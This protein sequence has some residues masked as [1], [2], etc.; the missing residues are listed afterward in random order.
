MT[1]HSIVKKLIGEIDPVGDCD[2]DE[3]RFNNL[4]NMINLVD[5]LIGDLERVALEADRKEFSV[6]RAG[7]VSNGFLTD[8]FES[9]HSKYERDW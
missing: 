8:L 4:N 1:H 3:D 2:E 6:K 5:C 9:L 7:I